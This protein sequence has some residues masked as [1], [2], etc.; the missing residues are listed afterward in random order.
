MSILGNNT[1]NRQT[2]EEIL[3]SL[4][5]Q[6]TVVNISS[7]QI[8][9]SGV[10]PIQLLPAAGTNKYY[11]FDSIIFEYIHNTTI[12]GDPGYWRLYGGISNCFIAATDMLQQPSNN[13]H[14]TTGKFNYISTGED[15][16]TMVE[17][18]SDILNMPVLLQNVLI[19]GVIFE[20]GGPSGGDGTL[21][22]ILRY[23]VRTVGQ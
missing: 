18:S 8:A 20:E 3:G 17:Y 7:A 21:R 10:T 14:I 9:S 15:D 16:S 22:L 6:T 19:G 23:K 13:V 12:W 1:L 5:Y 4:Q 11:E 2:I